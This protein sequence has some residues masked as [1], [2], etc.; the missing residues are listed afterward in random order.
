M[1]IITELNYERYLK[2]TYCTAICRN[3]TICHTSDSGSTADFDV[4]TAN[5]PA[6]LS[7]WGRIFPEEFYLLGYNAV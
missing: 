5:R 4:P 7:D 6:I 2:E 3:Y 1:I